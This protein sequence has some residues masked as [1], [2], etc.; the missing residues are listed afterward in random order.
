[1]TPN[2]YRADLAFVHHEGFSGF[3][4]RA[5]KETVRLLRRNGVRNGLVVDVG[6]G[7]GVFA[8]RLLA[9]GYDVFGLDLSPSMIRLA[10]K[11][12]PGARFH[13]GSF[14][15]AALPRC[16]AVV[17]M[18]EVVGYLLDARAARRLAA[19][20]ERVFDALAPG[21]LFVLDFLAPL[22]DSPRAW[23]RHETGDG[24]DV[25][26]RIS[27]DARRARLTR[28]IVTFR[29]AG[30]L[31]RRD[32]ETHRVKLW[33]PEEIS[34]LLSEAG[35]ELAIGSSYGSFRLPHGHLVALARK[36]PRPES[37]NLR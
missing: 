28:R 35:F 26:A 18:G 3:A 16:D 21:G 29:K 1:V 12:A 36:P 32:S 23:T 6:C 27:E 33:R 8:R 11:T 37:R 30:R 5:G 13:V 10:R 22:P 14:A 17:A 24:W 19:F 20:F 34:S 9:E 2:A 7:S 4:E 15:S 31:W 25:V